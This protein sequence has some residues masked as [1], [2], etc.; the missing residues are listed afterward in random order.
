MWPVTLHGENRQGGQ[1][2]WAAV[3]AAFSFFWA[4][5]GPGGAGGEGSG[6]GYRLDDAPRWVWAQLV[7]YVNRVDRVQEGRP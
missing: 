1:L 3:Q 5:G 6:K 7:R 2:T 4:T